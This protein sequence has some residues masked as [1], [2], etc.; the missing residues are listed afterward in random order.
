VLADDGMGTNI[1]AQT[2]PATL[3]IVMPK[4]RQTADIN[5]DGK[6]DFTD[7]SIVIANWGIPKDPRADLDEDGVVDLKDLSILVSRMMHR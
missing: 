2:I 1:L 4:P 6:V 7:L 3:N 5:G